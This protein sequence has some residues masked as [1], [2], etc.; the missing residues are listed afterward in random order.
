MK[1]W[2]EVIK[3]GLWLMC[4]ER[5]VYIYGAKGQIM[6]E[7][8]LDYFLSQERYKSF[9]AAEVKQ[10]RKNSLGKVAFDCSG[11]VGY[12]SDDM[13]YSAAQ[14]EHCRNV[15]PDLATGPAGS[16]LYTTYGGAGRHIGLDIGYGYC[17]HIAWESTDANIKAGKA[18]IVVDKIIGGRIPWEL[19]GMASNINYAGSDAR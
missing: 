12:I 9:S 7:E 4:Q 1:S 16:K 2:N 10:I 14:M 17:I 13:V 19:T 8:L 18:G 15:C 5:P 6:T 3:D 11:F